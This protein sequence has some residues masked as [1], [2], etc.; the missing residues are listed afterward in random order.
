[1]VSGGLAVFMDGVT[2][3]IETKMD[4]AYTFSIYLSTPCLI[5]YLSKYRAGFTFMIFFLRFIKHC[6]NS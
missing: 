6:G 4:F 5:G 3:E 1:M 2:L